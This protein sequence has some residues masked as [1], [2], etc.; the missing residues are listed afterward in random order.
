MPLA[1]VADHASSISYSIY[2]YTCHNLIYKDIADY[3]EVIARY[4]Y[5]KFTYDSGFRSGGDSDMPLDTFPILEQA[6]YSL[7]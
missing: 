4:G 3:E 1:S 5:G 7:Q 2:W 6:V